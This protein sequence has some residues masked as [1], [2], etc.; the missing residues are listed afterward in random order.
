MS[1]D[2]RKASVERLDRLAGMVMARLK[3]LAAIVEREV[4]KMAVD[5]EMVR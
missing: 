4:R 3:R 2:S 5:E 1:S